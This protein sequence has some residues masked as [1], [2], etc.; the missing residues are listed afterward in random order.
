[1]INNLQQSRVPLF[2]TS[3]SHFINTFI[4]CFFCQYIHFP[5]FFFFSAATLDMNTS[6]HLPLS[7][8]TMQGALS[9]VRQ[10]PTKRMWLWRAQSQR[11]DNKA[12]ARTPYH[13][14]LLICL[15]K[16]NCIKILSSAERQTRLSKHPIPLDREACSCSLPLRFKQQILPSCLHVG[17]A[18]PCDLF[19]V[20]V[21]GARRSRWVRHGT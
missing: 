17:N 20:A 12:A 15:S 3:L 8:V 21:E 13:C 11:M 6:S 9:L 2:K 7:K 10:T 16:Y 4:L 18:Q 1:V 14:P 5:F 19:S